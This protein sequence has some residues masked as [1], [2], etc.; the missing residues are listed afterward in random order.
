MRM[1][2]KIAMVSLLCAALACSPR[3]FLTRRLARDLIAGAEGFKAPQDFWL[4]TGLVSNRE[5]D[6]PETLVLQRRGWIIGTQQKCPPGMEPAPCWDVILSPA[7]V[8]AF[9]PLITNGASETSAIHV[10]R[11]E[12]VDITEISK[13]GNFADVEFTWHW[14][15]T[16][17]VGTAL[18][19]S[20]VRY[21]S[22]VAFRRYDD[23]WRVITEQLRSNQTLEDAL[24]NAQTAP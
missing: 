13:S 5:F 9:K 2:G 6:S 23:G 7:G 17:E 24:R 22:T 14:V 8:D 10:A 1:V 20:G 18:Y 16:N 15:A 3:D 19:D 12:F 4:K 11:R 21:R